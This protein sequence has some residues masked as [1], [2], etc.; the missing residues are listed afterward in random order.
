MSES[1]SKVEQVAKVEFD[2]TGGFVQLATYDDFQKEFE[3]FSDNS[4]RTYSCSNPRLEWMAPTI[5]P[6]SAKKQSVWPNTKVTP[7]PYG[8]LTFVRQNT[9]VHV[10]DRGIDILH[11]LILQLKDGIS[12]K[13][14]K[15]IRIGL[16]NH[17][18]GTHY[19]NEAS[20]VP[21]EQVQIHT[22]L[23]TIDQQLLSVM[24]TMY[25][26]TPSKIQYTSKLDETKGTTVESLVLPSFINR[27]KQP[28]FYSS[29][30][31]YSGLLCIEVEFKNLTP[32]PSQIQLF[33]SAITLPGV[34][35]STLG[36]LPI[37]KGYDQWMNF[38]VSEVSNSQDNSEYVLNPI[39]TRGASLKM[40]IISIWN[41]TQ[42]KF[43]T[44]VVEELIVHTFSPHTTILTA[45]KD[46]LLTDVNP[47]VLGLTPACHF[48]VPF[49]HRAT[50]STNRE[51]RSSGMW[52]TTRQPLVLK[53]MLNNPSRDKLVVYVG[54]FVPTVSKSAGGV[55][56]ISTA[57]SPPS[58]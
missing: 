49:S 41:D 58:N 12:F 29:C 42:Q 6:V 14:V 54:G 45:N 21:L 19:P 39:Q 50:F 1:L 30:C 4:Q 27:E 3:N 13:D 37:R 56:S 23:D 36:K 22:L 7:S 57:V 32:L 55:Y 11:D 53:M 8:P 17:A 24:S 26:K 2:F 16:C 34:C 44:N 43:V 48:L 5:Y 18:V 25:D 52:N 46:H 20:A 47:L 15:Q 31:Y 10:V 28:F 40:L 33:C 38:H 9:Y 35:R 51:Y